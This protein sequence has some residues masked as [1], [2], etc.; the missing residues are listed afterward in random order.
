MATTLGVEIDFSNGPSFGYPFILNDINFGIVNDHNVYN[1]SFNRKRYETKVGK[2]MI[3]PT[4][5]ALGA[6]CGYK[7][8][9]LLSMI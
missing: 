9:F 2:F 5:A 6:F 8:A 3:F 1:T 7:F 4:A